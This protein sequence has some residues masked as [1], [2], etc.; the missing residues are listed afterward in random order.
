MYERETPNGW[1]AA[2]QIW[3]SPSEPHLSMKAQ[4]NAV[5][6]RQWDRRSEFELSTSHKGFLYIGCP[7]LYS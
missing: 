7:K 3:M 4:I 2:E 6:Q 5:Q 1:Q